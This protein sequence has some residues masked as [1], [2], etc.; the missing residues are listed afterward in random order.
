MGW[1]KKGG[2]MKT[3]QEYKRSLSVNNEQI[4]KAF[5]VS[6]STVTSWIRRGAPQ[7]VLKKL[8]EAEKNII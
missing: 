4:S 2:Y 3:L 7:Q 1:F 8:N 5:D 6:M